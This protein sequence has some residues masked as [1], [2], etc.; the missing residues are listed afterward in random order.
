MIMINTNIQFNINYTKL[1][2][3][4]LYVIGKM[5]GA[6]NKYNLMK[7]MFESDR[8]HM[9][10]HM[11]PVTGDT[12]MRMDYGTVPSTILSIVNRESLDYYLNEAG[13]ESLPFS[14]DTKQDNAHIVVSKTP[15]D[16][17]YLSASDIEALDKGINEYGRLSFNEV[18]EKNHKE[19]CW[20]DTPA[21][22]QIP[23]ESILEGNHK[24]IDFLKENS[25]VIIL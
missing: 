7:I 18:K 17:D 12:Y 19:K 13:M 3:T 14:L 22:T 5:D 20:R 23:Y 2:H 1:I 16:T 21:N 25:R 9:I 10:K 8:H 6:V 15:A 11:R 24:V 4:I